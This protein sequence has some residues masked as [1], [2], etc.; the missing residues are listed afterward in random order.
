MFCSGLFQE[1]AAFC[2]LLTTPILFR[3]FCFRMVMAA[4]RFQEVLKVRWLSL[5]VQAT[6][7]QLIEK[8]CAPML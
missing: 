1:Q 7:N 2:H 4:S 3:K 6:T 5:T 8:A